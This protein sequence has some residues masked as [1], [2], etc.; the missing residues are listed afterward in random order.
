MKRIILFTMSKERL[1]IFSLA[2][3]IMTIE[4]GKAGAKTTAGAKGVRSVPDR[5]DR[6]NYPKSEILITTDRRCKEDREISWS[7]PFVQNRNWFRF[8]WS[9]FK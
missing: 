1:S 9:L 3:A 7:F 6:I 5:E 2:W 8:S 4:K